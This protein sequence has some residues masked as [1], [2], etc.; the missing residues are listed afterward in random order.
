RQH[1]LG[2]IEPFLQAVSKDPAMLIYLDNNSNVKGKP[3]ENYARE[4]ME[5]FALGVGNYTEQDIRQA[6]RAFTGSQTEEGQYNFDPD[7]HDDGEKTIFGQK[8]KFNGE[9]VVRLCV[10]KDACALFIARK[11]YRF[12]ISDAVT[13]PDKFLEPLASAFRKS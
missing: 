11:L 13:P 4:L 3:N 12:Y 7:L 5:L 2:K 10:K 6:A 9:D 8:G 1:A